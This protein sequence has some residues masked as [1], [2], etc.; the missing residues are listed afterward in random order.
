MSLVSGIDCR[1]NFRHEMLPL[2]DCASVT[3][4]SVSLT[5]QAL[6]ARS[7]RGEGARVG[8]SLSAM[9]AVEGLLSRV[10]ALVFLEGAKSSI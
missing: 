9:L 10:D 5:H 6:F 1:V 7:V 4:P 2:S 8:E 3:V